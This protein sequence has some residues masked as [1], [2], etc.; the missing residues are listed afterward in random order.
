MNESFLVHDESVVTKKRL[1]LLKLIEMKDFVSNEIK[2]L[3]QDCI[4]NGVKPDFTEKDLW[5]LV[6]SIKNKN[7]D[8]W[9][10]TNTKS[11]LTNLCFV[12]IHSFLF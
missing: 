11:Y 3:R 8:V 7:F 4:E 10:E 2:E 5:L 1:L 12:E 9:E 6:P